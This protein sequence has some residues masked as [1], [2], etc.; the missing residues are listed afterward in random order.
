MLEA[1]TTSFQIHLQ[2]PADLAAVY[3]NASV[4]ASGPLLA[5][6]GNSPLLFGRRLWEE[7]RIPLFEQAVDLRA[8]IS[9]PGG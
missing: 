9:A 4:A 1:A 7:T 8:S 6:C 3:Y 5:A 2:V